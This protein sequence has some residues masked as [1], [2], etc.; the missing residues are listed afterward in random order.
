[1]K[2]LW[3]YIKPKMRAIIF[4]FTVKFIGTVVELLLPWIL[5]I[6][7]NRYASAKDWDMTWRLGILM[8]FCSLFALGANVFANRLATKTARDI[9]YRLRQ[10]L[11]EKALRLSCRQ[12]DEFTVPSLISRLTSD[13][14]NVYRLIDRMQR[15]GVRA[16]IMLI[17]GVTITMLIEPVLTLVLL[18]VSPLL[19]IVVW[20]V[21][22]HGTKRYERTQAVLDQLIRRAQESMAG[23]RVIKALSKT[24]YEKASFEENNRE[25][26]QTEKSATLLMNVTGPVMN[27]LLN[28]ALTLVVVVG[29][30]R[31]SKGLAQT[32]TIIAFL[33]YFTLILMA[34]M[35]VSRLFMMYS[36]GAA[37]AHRIAEVLQAEPEAFEGKKDEAGEEYHVCF[38][39][40]SFSYDGVRN[41]LTEISFV[42]GRGQTLGI[43]G[44]TGSGKSTLLQLLLRFYLP[45]SGK[46]RIFGQDIQSMSAEELYRQFGVALQND[47]LYA[48]AI[49]DNICLGREID[50]DALARAIETAQAE[51]IDEKEG[52]LEYVI[53]SKGQDISGG[54]KQRLLLARALAGRPQIL[55]LDDSSSALDYKTDASLRAALVKDFSDTTKII[56][57]QRVSSIKEADQILVLEEGRLIGKGTHQEL[58]KSCTYYRDIA[59]IQMGEVE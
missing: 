18:A 23:I 30:Y 21:S 44:A 41:N 53:A 57:A 2:K 26:V 35:A 37:S 51:F 54:Q 59:A 58:L 5:A 16:P 47:F 3:I 36:K 55:L 22:R 19:I 6:I 4:G 52:G 1:M 43:I 7:L 38:E 24:E 32:G 27:F 46:I 13:T 42:L 49:R 56:V 9:T 34:L 20:Q 33:S 10:E 29:A 12:T 17:G 25:V 39:K 11:F 50:K 8:L 15:I 40:V 31:V 28:T 14:Y 45:Q 48:A